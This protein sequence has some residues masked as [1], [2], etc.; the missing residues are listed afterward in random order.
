M[1]SLFF[2]TRSVR[3]VIISITL[4]IQ[5]SAQNR[6]CAKYLIKS[7]DSL[8]LTLSS[9][10]RLA[11]IESSN[12]DTSGKSTVWTYVYF[13]FD[14]SNI[15]NSKAYYIIGQNNQVIYDH[16]DSLGVG[17]AIL[18]AWWMDS[19]SAVT[20]A[21]HAGGSDICRRFP[22]C[23]IAASLFQWP[24]P[25]FISEWRIAYHCSDSVRTIRV[26]GTNGQ[27]ITGILG[28]QVSQPLQF[29][30]RQNYP[31]PFNPSTTIAFS[32]PSTSPVSLKL[33]DRTGREVAVLVNDVLSPGGHS[34]RLVASTLSSG[35]YFYRLRT[36]WGM[37]TKKCLLLK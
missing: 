11:A 22:G 15:H 20:V 18:F 32:L 4:C 13:S 35:V 19:D 12:V 2:V 8:A 36:R 7:A 27:I 1:H 23:T 10:A 37:Q 34:T 29:Q 16:W 3:I 6:V 9:V 14:T 21:Q 24:A 31:N 17:P 5:S 25:P 33:F 28:P 30:L 26:N